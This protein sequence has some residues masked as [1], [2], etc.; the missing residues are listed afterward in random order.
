[1]S[2]KKK[3]KQLLKEIDKELDGV[4]D[5]TSSSKSSVSSES[6]IPSSSS[7]T[8]Y[9]S[10]KSSQSESS[11]SS[12]PSSSSGTPYFS[13]KSSSS[14]SESSQSSVPSSSSGTPYHSSQSSSSN[15]TITD[16]KVRGLMLT[17]AACDTELRV[18]REDDFANLKHK[19][20]TIL[21]LLDLQRNGP[22]ETRKYVDWA[23]NKTQLTPLGLTN[24]EYMNQ[25]GFRIHVV[26]LNSWG[27]KNGYSAQ[28]GST[29]KSGMKES[30]LYTYSQLAE[31][32]AFID[33]LLQKA[34]FI[35]G[36]M[37][38]LEGQHQ[39]SVPFSIEIAKYLREEKGF[40]GDIVF[41][42]IGGAVNNISQSLLDQ[43]NILI[44][45]SQNSP[46]QW[47]S[48]DNDIRNSDGMMEVSSSRPDII[49][50]ITGK[51]GPK[52]FYLWA[53]EL[54]G[55]ASG[56]TE[57]FPDAYVTYAVEDGSDPI[58]NPDPDQD[59]PDWQGLR[60]A[61]ER[62]GDMLWKPIAE[63]D[64][65]L[66]VL[67][68]A[69]ISLLKR[70]DLRTSWTSQPFEI[71]RYTG[72]YHGT[73][74][75][76]YRFTETGAAYPEPTFLCVTLNN[77]DAY[78]FKIPDP[79][80]RYDQ[81]II[82]YYF[83]AGGGVGGGGTQPIPP[84]DPDPNPDPNPP[85][86]TG[87]SVKE[88]FIHREMSEAHN[89]GIDSAISIATSGVVGKTIRLYPNTS[90]PAPSFEWFRE[91]MQ[92]AKN[93]GCIG[94]CVDIESS[95][96]NS[97]PTYCANLYSIAKS[98]NIPFWWEPKVFSGGGTEPAG[99]F[100][101]HWGYTYQQGINFLQNTCDGVI[102]WLYSMNA[103]S[104]IS[105]F[106]KLRSSGLTKPLIPLGDAIKRTTSGQLTYPFSAADIQQFYNNNYGVGF[107]VPGSITAQSMKSEGV[108]EAKNLY[109]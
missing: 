14:Q 2:S 59:L 60:L 21:T 8:P 103:S 41:N 52:G 47:E 26:L 44:A 99:H 86:N 62:K 55:N 38:L 93:D 27:I 85:Q 39:N 17:D 77:S 10:S 108:I 20:N 76:V 107:F 53:K 105:I 82:P 18:H 83:P 72:E 91:Q 25:E 80:Q 12:I 74:R 4:V 11:Q 54:V 79:E 63:S 22:R 42:I 23:R 19:Y 40:E 67:V 9:F 37:P 56:R 68:Q 45:S 70:V 81:V 90:S 36:I 71:G 84:P 66:V 75:Q 30:D 102:F 100:T 6:S 98:V 97:G 13:S 73:G 7:G 64:G 92:R 96:I 24:L 48:S 46:S 106:K 94:F 61:P 3:I 49:Q 29:Q 95:I 43:Y 89:L 87:I 65:K 57:S 31:E 1:M 101:R 34:P 58:P 50:L 51:P 32:K 104:W 16:L 28:M 15:S 69:P 78:I 35:S 88:V 109:S 5:I 33:D